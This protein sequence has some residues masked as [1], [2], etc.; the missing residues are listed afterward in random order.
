[1]IPEHKFLE[2]ARGLTEKTKRR[3]LKWQ[4][5]GHD[6]Y[7]LQ[8]TATTIRVRFQ[9]PETETDYLELTIASRN[10]AGDVGTWIVHEGEKTWEDVANLFYEIQQACGV[11]GDVMKEIE[12]LIGDDAPV[13][14]GARRIRTTNPEGT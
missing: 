4:S 3:Q 13:A 2:I 9:T 11:F 14:V 10:G 1:M 7:V 6:D 8:G 5:Q 12:S